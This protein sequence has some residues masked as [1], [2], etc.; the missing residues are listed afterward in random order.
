MRD[1]APVKRR[2]TCVCGG[3]LFPNAAKCS[4]DPP[5]FASAK[6]LGCAFF[7]RLA[8]GRRAP[9]RFLS[10]GLHQHTRRRAL[11]HKR[12]TEAVFTGADQQLL[13]ARA[14]Q[15]RIGFAQIVRSVRDAVAD[16]ADER[17]ADRHIARPIENRFYRPEAAPHLF[18]IIRRLIR[19]VQL[20][21]A[22]R[23]TPG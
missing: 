8:A 18:K 4:P 22:A 12:Q 19:P 21:R 2:W 13:A 15:E 20:N 9:A 11:R 1:L 10:C 17:H 14:D 7:F 23:F 16:A 5:R 3:K 6:G